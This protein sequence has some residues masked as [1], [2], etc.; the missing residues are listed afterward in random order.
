MNQ[1]IWKSEYSVGVKEIDLQHQHF[2]GLLNETY[3]AFE[4]PQPKEFVQN[5]IIRINDYAI[6]HFGTE[7][8]YFDKFN[9]EFSDEHK[10][11]HKKLISDLEALTINFESNGVGVVPELVDFLDR[12]LLEHLAVYDRKYI[13][14]FKAHGLS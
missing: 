1:I 12:W 2:I 11:Q 6:L 8:K 9:Y 3:E 10:E 13:P 4:K 14:C 5:L 7:E